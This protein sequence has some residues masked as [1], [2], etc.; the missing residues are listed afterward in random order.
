MSA[1]RVA[2]LKEFQDFSATPDHKILALG[3][4]RWLSLHA[5]VRRIL[6]QWSALSLYFTSANFDDPTH[7]NKLALSALKNPFMK[8]LMMFVDYA[9]GLLNDF[10][11]LFQSKSPIFYKLKTEILKLITTLAINYMDGTYVRNCTDLL[12]LDVTD[13]SHYVDVQKVYLGYIA[14]EELASLVSSQSRYLTVGGEEGLHNS[15]RL[16]QGGHY[17]DTETLYV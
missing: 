1:K 15:K 5:C 14:E 12:A 2:V 9:L 6:E 3:Q 13:E 16:L 4:T 17:P 10:N 7:C 8:V 11:V